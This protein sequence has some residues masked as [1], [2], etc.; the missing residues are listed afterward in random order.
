LPAK[1]DVDGILLPRPFKIVRHGPVRLFCH[2][3]PAMEDFY[4]NVLGF[5]QTEEVI[6]RNHR[7][8]FLRCN[9]EHHALALYPMALRDQL[10]L[11]QATT[12]LS[13]G[14]QVATYRQLKDAVMFL[15]E[16]GCRF[17]E[18]PSELTPGIDYCAYVLDPAGHAVQLYFRMEQI[19]WD[20]RTRTHRT[21]PSGPLDEWPEVVE[22]T[23][24]TYTGEPYLGPWG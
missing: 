10:G 6:W 5:V 1:Y 9:T 12:V 4:L 23:P 20:G 13:F 17:V 18:L 15:K 21:P 24:D 22:A 14:M 7:C 19:G 2:N 8:V 3:L 11:S 16:N